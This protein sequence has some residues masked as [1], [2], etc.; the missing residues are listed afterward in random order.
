[1]KEYTFKLPE[2]MVINMGRRVLGLEFDPKSIKMALVNNGGRPKLLSCEVL[3]LSGTTGNIATVLANEG[4]AGSL[5]LSVQE[6]IAGNKQMRKG[7]DAVSICV[8]NPQTVV[9]PMT[10]PLIPD[11]EI[12][13]A[14]EFQLSQSFHGI[15]S[16]HSISF[17]E[18]SRD[19]KQIY[20]I[21]SFSPLKVLE[22]YRNLLYALGYKHAFIDVAA[23]AQAKA[24]S[25]LIMQDKSDTIRVLCD[26]GRDLTQLT[27]ISGSVMMHSRQILSGDA[28]LQDI[29]RDR[30]GIQENEYESYRFH[31]LMSSNL[32][33][34]DLSSLF[35]I[36]YADIVEQLRQTIDFFNQSANGQK[37]VSEVVLI[38]G[39]SIFPKLED[40]FKSSLDIPVSILK[41]A[42]GLKVD[43]IIFTRTFS[44]IG[45]AIRTD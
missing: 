23:N 34:R 6:M 19:K 25:S 33:E 1:M 41:P 37:A 36:V 38:G 31:G 35:Q 15:S 22:G 43:P 8:N 4:D 21:V 20:G 30:I 16:T 5:A 14:V 42:A 17:K 32:P 40:Y 28:A 27:I 10:L 7:V 2:G 12:S 45:A 44:A 13:A 3:Q 39:G 11:K 29:I 26:I 9:R 18:Y 24:Y